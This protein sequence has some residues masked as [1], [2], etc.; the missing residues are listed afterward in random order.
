MTSEHWR[1]VDRL[2]HEAL[3]RPA[4]QRAAFLAGA[5]A[6]DAALER[7]VQ[8]LLDQASVP[9]FLEEPALSVAAAT[10]VGPDA[11]WIDRHI[12]VY[13]VQA[14]LGRGGMGEVYRAHDARLGRDVAIKVLPPAFTSDPDRLARFA[15]EARVLASL[16]HPNIGTI[17]G[18][19][20]S[21][22]VRALVLELVEGDTLADRIA[23]RPLPVPEA[24]A[25]ARQI[26]DALEAAHDKGIVHR[27]LKPANIKI[28]PA[29]VVK[30]LDFGLAKND[31]ETASG[32]LSQSPTITAAGTGAGII[33]GTAAYMSPEQARG[34]A[35]DKRGDVW[36]FGCVLYEMLTGRV[37]FPGETVSDTI[38]AI[39]QREPDWTALPP[40]LP[41]NIITLLRRCLERDARQRKRDIGDAR[42]ELDGALS[43]AVAVAV[44]SRQAAPRSRQALPWAVALAGAIGTIAGFWPGRAS[45]NAWENP[46]AGAKFSELTTFSG[47]EVD[48]VISPD[49]RDVA[50]LS[51]QA[52][53]FD[54]WFGR[55]GQGNFVNLTPD[56]ANEKQNATGARDIG[57]TGDGSHVWLAGSPEGRR[58]YLLP[59]IGG[60]AP[61]RFLPENALNVAWAPDGKRIVFYKREEGDPLYVADADGTNARQIYVGGPSVHNHGPVWSP[62]G[63]W[64]YFISG[65]PSTLEHTI[66]RIRPS[67]EDHQVLVKDRRDVNALVPLDER[68]L[69]Y[70][71][72][73]E[74]G[75]GPWLWCLDLPTGVSHRVSSGLEQYTSIGASADGRKLVAAVGTPTV[76]LW[77]APIR[78]RVVGP[79]DVKR[80]TLSNARALGPRVRG[81]TTYYLS[82]QGTGDGLWRLRDEIAI[83]IWPG[84]QGALLEPPAISADGLH[85]AI[86]L[87][88]GGKRTLRIIAA[89]G[90]DPRNLGESIEV[91]GLVDWSPDGQWLVTGGRDTRTKKDGL[92]KIPLDGGEP[93]PL[94]YGKVHDP[95]WSPT[96][97]LILY[98]GENTGG[99]SPLLGIRSD[100]SDVPLPSILVPRAGIGGSH[101]FLPDGTGVVYLQGGVVARDFWLL[102]LSNMKSRQLTD[103]ASETSLGVIN[104]F[105]ITHDGKS[106]VFDR[107]RDNSNIRL[108]ERRPPLSPG[109]KP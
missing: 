42:A 3:E 54:V 88:S 93:V 91:Q 33:L 18:L 59:I 57:F 76:G 98:S 109:R 9:G 62:D 92:F 61:K 5:C 46:L 39:L 80:F 56:K 1:K 84:S 32:D 95:V 79:A 34:H 55:I 68:S 89:D 64:I 29:N 15:R 107:L 26:A 87:R 105:D 78:D 81:A 23:R 4:G 60:G 22:G 74:D 58:L 2:Y 48:A 100:G 69:L 20:E 16:N 24:L 28:T 12:G 90:T 103:I 108:I 7:E 65:Y 6:G 72:K 104:G 99:R 51:D 19:E 75:S 47:S 82:A 41:P 66:D 49:G 11:S 38:A 77:T 45:S 96:D 17:Y 94:R 52:G 21:D 40:A 8:S 106:I 83:E 101:R 13:Q 25:V 86:V 27:D 50:F 43:P 70:V 71:S 35:V 10:A 14:L 53:Q 67:N 85:V 31:T 73:D 44:P 37:A 97:D 36:A 63:E 102:T 30:V